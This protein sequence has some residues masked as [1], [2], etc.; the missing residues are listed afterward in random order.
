M[1]EPIDPTLKETLM[2]ILGVVAGS[3]VRV[4]GMTLVSKGA[5]DQA[6]FD[7]AYTGIV[8][9][10]AGGLLYSSA[11][12]WAQIKTRLIVAKDVKTQVLVQ[13]KEQVAPQVTQQ[14]LTQVKDQVVQQVKDQVPIEVKA[15]LKNQ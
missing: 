13:V 4:I 6:T 7:A 3:I 5:V 2:P 11:Q 14:V 10:V 9:M 1:N 8:E 15:E 12:I